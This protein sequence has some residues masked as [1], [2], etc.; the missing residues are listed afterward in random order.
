MKFNCV[1]D[2]NIIIS[3]L[4]KNDSNPGKI[5][6][7]VKDLVIIPYYNANILEEYQKVLNYEKFFFDKNT[8][9]YALALFIKKGFTQ[10]HFLHSTFEFNDEY[11]QILYETYLSLSSEKEN[12]YL[13]TGNK[14]IFLMKQI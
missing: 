8:S 12:C 1:I 5:I 4:L 3:A 14:S 10:N 9:L 2:T 11:D 6:K 7:F 13:I